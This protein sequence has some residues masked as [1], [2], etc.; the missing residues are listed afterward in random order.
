V[1]DL[2][3]S[4]RKVLYVELITGV[5]GLVPKHWSIIVR[6]LGKSRVDGPIKNMLL[7]RLDHRAF[8]VD[9]YGLGQYCEEVI[10]KKRKPGDMVEVGVCQH[11]ISD[12]PLLLRA[13]RHRQTACV[14]CNDIIDDE[15]SQ[16]LSR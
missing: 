12:L 8:G 16:M 1:I 6:K 9:G 11:D 14:D 10:E 15:T 2:K 4:K 5:K 7:K 3:G 13:R